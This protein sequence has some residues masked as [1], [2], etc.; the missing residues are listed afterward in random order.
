MRYG[1]SPASPLRQ[2]HMGIMN[3]TWFVRDDLVMTIFLRRP[4]VEVKL[5]CDVVQNDTS[6]LLPRILVGNHG[7][8]AIVGGKAGVMLQRVPGN[9]YV[10]SDHSEKIPMPES[11]HRSIA[12]S[13]WLLHGYL[14]GK[15]AIGERLGEINYSAS[16]RLIS[17]GI[18]FSQLPACLHKDYIAD[19]LETPSPSLR[20]PTLVHH[21]FERQNVLHAPDGKV[22]GVVDADAFRMGDLLF[23][24]VHCM[25]DFV[26]TDPQY[27]SS[28]LDH[29]I[30]A[31]RKA[32]MV[33][34]EHIALVPGLLRFFAARDL[35]NYY[36][37]DQPPR[38][39]LA[40]LS[41]IYDTGLARAD[42]YFSTFSKRSFFRS[43]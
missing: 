42:K 28:Y 10:G 22:T 33:R 43:Q 3:E 4:L 29:Y 17:R 41:A 14:S 34:R 5:I 12:E 1:I 7:P 19:H 21:D 6:G 18:S 24:Y 9:H 11:A 39:N 32:G 37:Y 23:E 20:Y 2:G 26:L 40:R 15:S 38:T 30:T 36:F 8:V 31:L 16:D 35:V 13:F 27:Q 25:M